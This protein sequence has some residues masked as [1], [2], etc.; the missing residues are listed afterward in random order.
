MGAGVA[1][2]D[3]LVGGRARPGDGGPARDRRWRCAAARPGV[4]AARS[5]EVLTR[6]LLGRDAAT[7]R[8]RRPSGRCHWPA[9]SAPAPPPRAP[10][11]RSAR[12]RCTPKIPSGGGHALGRRGGRRSGHADR[13]RSRACWPGGRSRRRTRRSARS[14]S[15]SI[16]PRWRPAAR[17][18]AA[19]RLSASWAARP[20]PSPPLEE[21]RRRGDRADSLRARARGRPAHRRP[22]DQ[23]PDRRGALPEPQDGRDPRSPPLR[24]ARRLV[25]R[26]GRSRRRARRAHRHTRAAGPNEGGKSGVVPMSGHTPRRDARCLD[27]SRPQ[28]DEAMATYLYKLAGWTFDNRRKVLLGW[29][30]V[31]AVVIAGAAPSAGS[32]RPS[33]RSPA[34]SRRRLRTSCT[35]SIRAPAAPRRGLCSRLPRASG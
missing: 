14:P 13:G 24:E 29:L 15:W 21:G 2:A 10:S 31:L 19:T 30:A 11:A 34:P 4:L 25:A 26:R 18:A 33:S 5:F 28:G 32:S 35:R 20:A 23:L 3:A 1:L 9:R 17:W 8:P 7:T 12:S 27:R 6:S 16:R 22:Q